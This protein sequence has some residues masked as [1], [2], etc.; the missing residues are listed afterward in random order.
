[1]KKGENM[2]KFMLFIVFCGAIFA[3]TLDE[4]KEKGVL[5]IGVYRDNPPIC[6]V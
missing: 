3:N 6:D 5:R 2:K 4:I 1:M